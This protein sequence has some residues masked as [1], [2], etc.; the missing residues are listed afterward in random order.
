MVSLA[1]E[2][3]N[4]DIVSQYEPLMAQ[5][6]AAYDANYAGAEAAD[7]EFEE[8]LKNIEESKE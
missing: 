2:L 6:K 7:A 4:G 8:E 3:G 5:T 1:N